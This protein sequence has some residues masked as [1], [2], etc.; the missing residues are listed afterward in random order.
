MKLRSLNALALSIS[1][2]VAG[3]SLER[4]GLGGEGTPIDSGPSGIDAGD[5]GPIVADAGDAGP[6][7]P[8]G[9]QDGGQDGGPCG[10]CAAPSICCS[11]LCV[12]PTSDVMHCGGCDA[13]PTGPRGTATC[14]ASACGLSC[15]VGWADCDADATNGCEAD[16][17]AVTSCGAC[18]IMCA[19]RPASTVACGGAGCSYICD[20]GRDD[21]DGDPVNGCE[22][23]LASVASCGSCGSACATPAGAT[24]TCDGT[25]CGFTCLSGRDDCD[26][27]PGNGCEADLT[28]VA[29]C[30]ACG[31]ACAS[32]P[33]ATA[34]CGAGG[35]GFSCMTGRADCDGNA[36]S[37]CESTLATDPL[38]CGACGNACAPGRACVAGGCVGWT[39][40]S[41]TGLPAARWDHSA[42][43]TGTEMIIWGG[44]GAGGRLNDG[45]AYDPATDT[46]RAITTTGAPGGRR[47]HTAVW[48]GTEMVIWGGYSSAPFVGGFLDSGGAYDVATDTWRALSGTGAPSARSRV[49]DVWTGTQMLIW[50]G[51]NAGGDG[52]R[53]TASTNAWSAISTSGDPS[54]R[55]WNAAVWTG[56][57]ML[58]VFGE[59]SGGSLRGDGF[60]YDPVGNAWTAISG[61][62]APDGRARSVFAWT[63]GLASPVLIVWGGDD[64]NGDGTPDATYLANGGRYSAASNTWSGMAAAPIAGRSIATA[65]W[66]GSEMIVWGGTGAGGALGDG[67]AYD[68][69]ANAWSPVLA[70]GSPVARSRHTAVWTGSEMI[71]FGGL[72]AGGTIA[73]PGR[74]LP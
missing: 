36:L 50:G 6:I 49:P 41:A 42:I 56:S 71:V 10:P 55:R 28:S 18:D 74:Y 67:A 62:G 40:L 52:A 3:C 44:E 15:E 53:W 63:T 51:W 26:G 24:A 9:G 59:D 57:R 22:S 64:G 54:S 66:T 60:A 48:T 21:C 20:I 17:G 46:W 8:D 58:V 30:G 25:A 35:C 13:C 16:L 27:L 47:G 39:G 5:A 2:L 61:S 32:P 70:A 1:M 29:S 19:T 38:N 33:G 45:H 14:A 68:P 73:A 43:W 69:V 72:N 37:G 31:L 7:V 65:V 4:V 12:D 23:D 11:G 34:T